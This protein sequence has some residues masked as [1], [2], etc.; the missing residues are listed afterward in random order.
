MCSCMFTDRDCEFSP[1]DKE[2]G[3]KKWPLLNNQ[4]LRGQ[5]ER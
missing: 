5:H 3:E 2:P 4:Y 1:F